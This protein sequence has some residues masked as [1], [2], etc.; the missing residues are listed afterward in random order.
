MVKRFSTVAFILGTLIHL[1]GMSALFSEEFRLLAE[2]KRTGV[3]PH[4]PVWLIP[5]WWIW[6]PVPLLIHHACH[7]VSAHFGSG[8]LFEPCDRFRG[9]VLLAWSICVGVLFGFL[10]PRIF[11]WRRKTI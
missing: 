2:F 9:F 11:R 10:V 4:A 8:G 3:D 7:A 1:A 6:E 5:M